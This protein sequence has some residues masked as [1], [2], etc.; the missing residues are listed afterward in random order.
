MAGKLCF[1]EHS[2]FNEN[3]AGWFL[4]YGE[5]A[6]CQWVDTPAAQANEMSSWRNR[7]SNDS[8]WAHGTNGNGTQ[9]CMDSNSRDSYV[10]D[11]NNDQMQSSRLLGVDSAC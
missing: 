9:H 5:G 10:G 11:A 7:R 1:W 6:C 4:I 8:K 2:N 3:Q